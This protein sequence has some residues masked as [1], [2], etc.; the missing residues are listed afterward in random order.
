MALNNDVANYNS[1]NIKNE[2]KS[3]SFTVNYMNATRATADYM[4]ETFTAAKSTNRLYLSVLSSRLETNDVAGFKKYAADLYA[5]GTPIYV[6][7]KNQTPRIEEVDLP[8][9]TLPQGNVKITVKTSVPPSGV[10]LS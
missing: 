10:S 8:Q 6:V 3:N 1:A 2:I 5:A 7:Y 4:G 9:I